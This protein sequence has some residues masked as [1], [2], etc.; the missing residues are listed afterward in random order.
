MNY[1]PKNYSKNYKRF[2]TQEEINEMSYNERFISC[3]CC[4][5]K[6]EL[7][8]K[9][10]DLECDKGMS[11]AITPFKGKN[12]EEVCHRCAPCVKC[13][14]E[15][16][17]DSFNRHEKTNDNPSGEWA[18]AYCSGEC[19]NG[20]EKPSL[21]KKE[22]K[23]TVFDYSGICDHCGKLSE[24]KVGNAYWGKSFCSGHCFELHFAREPSLKKRDEISGHCCVCN[25]RIFGPDNNFTED[26]KNR[27]GVVYLSDKNFHVRYCSEACFEKRGDK[28]GASV[29]TF[30]DGNPT[31]SDNSPKPNPATPVPQSI[32]NSNDKN[33]N[34]VS[35]YHNRIRNN[36]NSSEVKNSVKTIRFENKE[37]DNKDNSAKSNEK[38][39]AQSDNQTLIINLK[40]VK[41]ITLRNDGKL[42]IEFNN[43]GENNNN[44]ISK[45]QL[46]SSEQI[47]NNS[48]LQKIKDYC[49]KNGKNSL[50]QQELNN[51]LQAAKNNSNL[52]PSPKSQN[53]RALWISVGIGGILIIGVIAGLLVRKRKTKMKKIR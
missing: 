43:A 20:T 16:C 46:V 9:K 32:T 15:A 41:N 33:D 19:F 12:G 49:Q 11:W 13:G 18:L 3:K 29:S 48:E 36:D 50:N 31:S 7:R 35:P 10:S 5:K 53:Y 14:K 23:K 42:E 39:P 37:N 17:G 25:F 26:F 24:I 8:W 30:H 52:F 27:K 21:P 2:V 44:W 38:S 40:E 51:L 4:G 45:N 34:S 1:N 47:V 22:P 6:P 28:S